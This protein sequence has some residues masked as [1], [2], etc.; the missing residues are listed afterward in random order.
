MAISFQCPACSADLVLS[1]ARPGHDAR[2]TSCGAA[3][4][5]PLDARQLAPE[6]ARRAMGARADQGHLKEEL[7]EEI[8][9]CR[10][11]V[12][13]FLMTPI[14]LLLHRRFLTGGLL[15]LLNVVVNFA[16][17]AVPLLAFLGGVLM[18]AIAVYFGLK[19]YRIAWED[20]GYHDTVEDVKRRERIW[21][22]VGIVIAAAY[23][24]LQILVLL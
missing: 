20:R 6:E 18:I 24:A 2:C 14:W 8:A 23:W 5:V 19:G 13:A 22:V 11:N 7:P 21:A 9:R 3:I 10:F 16:G 1:S 17:A 15:I 12:G 4:V